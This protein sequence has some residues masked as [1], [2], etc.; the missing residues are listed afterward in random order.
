MTNVWR[1]CISLNLCLV[2]LGLVCAVMGA[3][4]FLLSGEAGQGINAMPLFN[5]LREVTFG[6]S[7]WLWLT[8]VLFALLTANTVCCSFETVRLRWRKTG[9]MA[10]LAP[11]LIHAGFLLIVLAH[12]QSASGGFLQQLEIHEGQLARLP[13]GHVFGL[14]SVSTAYSPQGMPVGCSGELVVD[15]QAPAQRVTISPNHPWFCGGYGVYI[16]QVEEFPFRRAL[17]EIHR[18]PGAGTALAGALLFSCG[19][20][21]LLWRRS[22]GDNMRLGEAVP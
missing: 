10:L 5:W 7:W 2:V 14:A 17:L 3:G 12:V 19:T 6:A 20:V 13:D 9:I 11:Q 8:M 16:K 4:S 18:E 22:K 21:A 15:L 1:H